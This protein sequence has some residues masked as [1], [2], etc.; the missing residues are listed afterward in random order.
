MG[1]L[2]TIV[3]AILTIVLIFAFRYKCKSNRTWV[4][5]WCKCVS[6]FSLIWVYSSVSKVTVPFLCL[7]DSV[8]QQTMRAISR[9]ET[10]TYSSQGCSGSQRHRGAWGSASSS[11]SSPVCA[12]C[13]EEFQDGQVRGEREKNISV[14]SNVLVSYIS[15]VFDFHPSI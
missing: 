4:S 8:H 12:I 6:G 1:I 7:Q 11:N 13:L 9:L 15:F 3:L 5:E 10:K 14:D 2:L